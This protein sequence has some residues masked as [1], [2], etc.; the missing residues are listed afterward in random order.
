[1]STNQDLLEGS[2]FTRET[3]PDQPSYDTDEIQELDDA[4]EN[5]L[6]AATD[7]SK[8]YL[9][10]LLIC[11]LGSLRYGTALNLEAGQ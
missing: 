1:M 4:H 7:A 2:H 3:I 10:H 5:A 9:E 11:E 8:D 6:E